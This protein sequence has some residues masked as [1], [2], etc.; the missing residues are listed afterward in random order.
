MI[1]T[2]REDSLHITK[3]FKELDENYP[4]MVQSPMI[5]NDSK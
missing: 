2:P 4:N 3:K 5:N 1:K